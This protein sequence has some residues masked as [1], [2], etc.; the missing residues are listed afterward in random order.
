MI[1]V[2]VLTTTIIVFGQAVQISGIVTSQ[3]DGLGIPGVSV[4]V[5]GTTIGVLTA[6]DGAYSLSV[7]PG[8]NTLVFSFIGMKK[9]EVEIQ[10]RTRIDVVLQPDLIA[11]DEVVVIGGGA[12]VSGT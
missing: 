3:E 8:S 11:M 6:A 4:T 7:P 10:G 12:K 1:F 9:T 2:L 5:K